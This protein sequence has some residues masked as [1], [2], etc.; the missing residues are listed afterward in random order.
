MDEDARAFVLHRWAETERL[1]MV[2]ES[3]PDLHAHLVRSVEA[4]DDEALLRDYWPA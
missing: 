1:A 2:A 4:Q 3:A